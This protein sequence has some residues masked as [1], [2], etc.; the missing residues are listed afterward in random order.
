MPKIIIG[1][2]GPGGSP[3]EQDLKNAYAT[4][5]F[6]AKNNLTVFFIVFIKKKKKNI[7]K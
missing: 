7:K 6:C 1:V 2:M 5:K 4:G 3:K